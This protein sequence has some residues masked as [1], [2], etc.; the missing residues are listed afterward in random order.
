MED[1]EWEDV[2]VCTFVPLVP[3]DVQINPSQLVKSLEKVKIEMV[4]STDNPYNNV[5]DEEE[6]EVIEETTSNAG[7]QEEILTSLEKSEEQDTHQK[8]SRSFFDVLAVKSK[9]L[10]KKSFVCL[11]SGYL[12]KQKYYFLGHTDRA[13]VLSPD[14]SQPPTLIENLGANVDYITAWNNKLYLFTYQNP[15]RVY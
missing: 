7:V 11:G 15:V 13:V 12:N 4:R 2:L 5:A 9:S 14:Q 10:A 3:A 6:C 8:A 1:E